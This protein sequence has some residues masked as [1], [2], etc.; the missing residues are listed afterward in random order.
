MKAGL[1]RIYSREQLA[2]RVAALGRAVSMDYGDRTVDVVVILEN[3]FV[4]AADLVRRM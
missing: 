4:F 2:N 1:R 3:A